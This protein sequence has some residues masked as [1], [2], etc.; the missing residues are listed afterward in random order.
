MTEFVKPQARL[1]G[2]LRVGEGSTGVKDRGSR[3][4]SVKRFQALD[5]LTND[6]HQVDIAN[7]PDTCPVCHHAI[8]V[9]TTGVAALD[10]S[11]WTSPHAKLEIVYRCPRKQCARLFIG[12]FQHV[13]LAGGR[14]FTQD[15]ALRALVP[16]EPRRPDTPAEVVHVSPAY[17]QIYAQ[18][19]AAEA[20]GLDQIAGVGYRKALEFLI[21]DYCITENEADETAI[22]SEPLGQ[23]I[24]NRVADAN[25]RQCAKLAAWLGN[26]ETHYERRWEDKDIKDLKILI[27]LTVNWIRSVLLTAR[28]VADMNPP[29]PGP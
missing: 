1:C 18:A 21:K 7:P 9:K 24:N 10:Q 3:M 20:F 15:F 23:T 25:V 2:C 5:P 16:T 19:S 6:K 26:D 28:Y 17:A 8:E 13:Q 14:S 29:K 11:D 4:S 22:K 12:R 27:Q